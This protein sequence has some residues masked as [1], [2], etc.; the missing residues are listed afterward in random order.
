[1]KKRRYCAGSPFITYQRKGLRIHAGDCGCIAMH[2]AHRFAVS[3]TVLTLTMKRTY[4]QSLR[5][6]LRRIV[7]SVLTEECF[8]SR[9][10]CFKNKIP[11][12][13]GAPP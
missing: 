12:R 4:T 6:W 9:K 11:P 13:Y 10:L 3:I 8:K 2:G 5:A 7:Q 1:M